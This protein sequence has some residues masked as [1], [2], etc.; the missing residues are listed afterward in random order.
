MLHFPDPTTAMTLASLKSQELRAEAAERRMARSAEEQRRTQ[1]R[2]A[3][4]PEA[5]A[6]RHW[7]SLL[8]GRRAGASHRFSFH[9]S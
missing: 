6:T 9:S 1:R 2:P 7:F 3:S 5:S 4:T 8:P